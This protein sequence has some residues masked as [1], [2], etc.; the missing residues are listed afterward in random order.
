MNCSTRPYQIVSVGLL[1]ALLAFAGFAFAQTTILKNGFETKPG[2]SKGGFDTTYEET[3]HRID[4]REPHNGQGS[5]FIELDVK[6]GKENGYIHYVYPV[7]KAPIAD[8]LRIAVWLRANRPGIQIGAR[9][10]L[11]SERD[12]QNLNFSLT[13]YIRG[14]TYQQVGRWQLLDIGRPVNLTKQQQGLMN[15]ASKRSLDFT[16]ASTSTPW[17]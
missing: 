10:V 6:Q 15:A 12:P 2:W 4:D 9:V 5:E 13:T 7:G 1:A 16:G 3:A 17:C 11:P 8:E 14:D